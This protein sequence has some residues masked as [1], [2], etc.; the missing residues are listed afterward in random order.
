MIGFLS[1]RKNNA[2]QIQLPEMH[3]RSYLR[4]NSP[5]VAVTGQLLTFGYLS[6]ISWSVL[7]SWG[8]FT[9]MSDAYTMST[10]CARTEESFKNAPEERVQAVSRG[11]KMS[12]LTH[13]S[14]IQ[15]QIKSQSWGT[16]V[17]QRLSVCLQ[18]RLWSRG[19]GI[20]FHIRLPTESLLLPLP[21][22]LP[23]CVSFMNK[24]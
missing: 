19:P 20:K 13:E 5:Q 16:W 17:A 9:G 24:F 14:H 4:P 10:T 18:L 12:D 8:G 23:L 22:S 3:S 1:E 6:T 2:F 7:S 15:S 11:C 21:M